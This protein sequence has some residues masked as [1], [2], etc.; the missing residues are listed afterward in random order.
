MKNVI[1]GVKKNLFKLAAT[2]MNS[3]EAENDMRM[4]FKIISNKNIDNFANGLKS[5]RTHLLQVM[6]AL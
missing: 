3:N 5:R 4:F 1:F 6:F 2:I